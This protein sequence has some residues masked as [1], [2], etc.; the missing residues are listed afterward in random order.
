MTVSDLLLRLRAL[1]FRA[2][3]EEE[4]EDEVEFHLAMAAASTST[5]G[6]ARKKPTAWRVSISAESER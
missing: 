6:A 3:V 5:P 1:L 2:R 4:L